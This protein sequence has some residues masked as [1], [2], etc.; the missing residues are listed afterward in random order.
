MRKNALIPY[1]A[2]CGTP[3]TCLATAEIT[4]RGEPETNVQPLS[5]S[6]CA[7]LNSSL[8]TAVKDLSAWLCDE[9]RQLLHDEWSRQAVKA[10]RLEIAPGYV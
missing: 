9:G 2:L 8:P 5:L 4:D 1:L 3:L 10:K 7:S 6:W